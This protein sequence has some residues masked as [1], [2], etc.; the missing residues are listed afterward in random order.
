MYFKKSKSKK[1]VSRASGHRRFPEIDGSINEELVSHSRENSRLNDNRPNSVAQ[2]RISNIAQL[3]KGSHNKKQFIKIKSYDT[4][5]I[6]TQVITTHTVN[7]D[8]DLGFIKGH[9]GFTD[10]DAFAMDFVQRN[11]DLGGE[12][13]ISVDFKTFSRK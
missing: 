11:Y 1:E 10:W 2:G 4:Q 12:T 3:G 7:E 13:L 5:N 6:N 8:H 9:P